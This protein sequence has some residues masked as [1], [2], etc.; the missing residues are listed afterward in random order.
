MKVCMRDRRSSLFCGRPSALT[1]PFM[2]L[3][4]YSSAFNSGEYVGSGTSSI[5]SL[6]SS[7][8]RGLIAPEN[9]CP[10]YPGFPGQFR[11]GLVE[12][13]VHFFGVLVSGVASGLLGGVAPAFEI[14]AYRP[15]RHR[16]AVLVADQVLNG[17]AGPQGTGNA[18]PLGAVVVDQVLEVLGLVVGQSA[19]GADR[20]SRAM[21]RQSV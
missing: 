1:F 4:R 21:T 12:P 17:P 5:L 11:V 6:C 20:T 7:R 10:F 9:V 14:L 19:T 2:S 18:Q 16:D 3:F 15:N 13:L 8:H